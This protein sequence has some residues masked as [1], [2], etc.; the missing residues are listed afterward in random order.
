MFVKYTTRT[1]NREGIHGLPRELC[2]M[3]VNRGRGYSAPLAA[4]G[5]GPLLDYTSQVSYPGGMHVGFQQTTDTKDVRNTS[6]VSGFNF[7]IYKYMLRPFVH[8]GACLLSCL[9]TKRVTINRE[10]YL[11]K[12]CK[13]NEIHVHLFVLNEV[14]FSNNTFI[15]R[16]CLYRV[17]DCF[18]EIR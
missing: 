1:R 3:S 5:G 12:T 2:L 7:N 14:T 17:L 9:I 16:N 6:Q 10:S 15:T 11:N 13:Y 8:G 18:C 4:S